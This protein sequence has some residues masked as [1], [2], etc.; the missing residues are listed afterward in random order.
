MTDIRPLSAA[1][2]ESHLPA[3]V[4]L[5]RS[6]VDD[7]ASI[8]FLPPVPDAE[9]D[10]YWREVLPGVAEGGRVLIGAMDGERL[11][12]CVQLALEGRANGRH[13]AEIQKLMVLPDARGRGLGAA[14]MAAAEDAARAGGRTLLVLDTRE[15]DA[16]ERLYRRLGWTQ[17]GRI[18]GYALNAD[19]GRDAT[20]FFYRELAQP[21]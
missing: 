5:L 18:P 20:L 16:A 1:E 13:R 9:A 19:G 17:A 4:S 21:G 12:G 2:A 15:G 8:G 3:L 7:G 11:L 6:T 14:L 10:A